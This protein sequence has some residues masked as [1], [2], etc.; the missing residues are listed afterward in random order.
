MLFGNIFNI[1]KKT[2]FFPYFSAKS[3]LDGSIIWEF[4]LKNV[5]KTFTIEMRI[6]KL[7]TNYEGFFGGQHLRPV[8][9]SR[10]LADCI[11]WALIFWE[12]IQ[13]LFLPCPF[14][15]LG[16]CDILSYV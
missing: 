11:K 2:G 10:E 3:P 6:Y 8:L 7:F 4:I 12:S 16:I 9:S 14:T 5:Y 1:I 13:R 15:F